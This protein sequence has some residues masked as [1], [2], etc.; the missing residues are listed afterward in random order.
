MMGD[1][2][3]QCAQ[4]L[5][6]NGADAIGANCGELSPSQ[7]AI[8]M[9]ELRKATSLPLVAQPNAGKPRLE[10][11]EAI[12]DMSPELFVQ[13]IQE[14]IDAGA[15]IVGGC[16]GTTPEHIAAVAKMLKKIA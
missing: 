10:G 4:T 14:C 6:D 7:T 1:A 9:S 8:V 16:C 13:G 12:F 5:A 15:T 2:A 11:E 3:E